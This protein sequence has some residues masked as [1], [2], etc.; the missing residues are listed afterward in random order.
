VLGIGAFLAVPGSWRVVVDLVGVAV[1][2]GF[3]TVP[4]FTLLQHRPPPDR[5]S[6]VIA[7]NNVVNAIFV[8]SSSLFLMSLLAAGFEIPTVFLVLALLNAA[9]AIFI[10]AI[11]PDFVLRFLAWAVAHVMYRISCTGEE[12]VP[13][14]GPAVLVANQVSYVDWLLIASV[15]ARPVRFVM[16]RSFL[17]P[18]PLD[19]VARGA[20]VIPIDRDETGPGLASALDRIARELE[21]GNVVCLFPEGG[22][23]RD[24]RLQPFLVGIEQVLGRSPVPVIPIAISGM[25]GS[26]FSRRWGRPMSRPFR[27]IWSRVRVT[28]GEPVPPDQASAAELARRVAALGGWDPPD[29]LAVPSQV[30]DHGSSRPAV[31]QFFASPGAPGR[32][33]K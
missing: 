13:L 33:H 11:L 26:Y 22:M 30:G 25:W 3:Y 4:L 2:S 29:P 8:V 31:A 15:S 5:R 12:H 1:S 24:G 18:G 16:D 6:R 9:V 7:A 14:D 20:R 28:L 10:Y 17:P 19:A 21:T 32:Q 27:R 23:T